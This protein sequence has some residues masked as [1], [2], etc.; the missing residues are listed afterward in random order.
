M[1]LNQAQY[2]ARRAA[3]KEFSA[4]MRSRHSH[5]VASRRFDSAEYSARL[6][7]DAKLRE[8][9]YDPITNR[10]DFRF[11]NAGE[12]IIDQNA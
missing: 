7:Y 8:Y 3:I 4:H 12:L 6:A 1:T 5:G 11:T 10:Q 9:G 2:H